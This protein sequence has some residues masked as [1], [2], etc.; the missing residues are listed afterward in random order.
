MS[1][2]N[3][4]I[5][6]LFVVLVIILAVNPKTVNNIYSSILGR[7]FLIGVIIFFAMHNTTL[8][9]LVALAVITALNQYGSFTEGMENATIGDDNVDAT[10]GQI[11][12]TK[13]AVENA[14]KKISDL[15]QDISDGTS[16]IDKEDIKM[17]IMSKD[18]KTIPV[19]PNM[20]SSEEVDASSQGML[21]S[22]AKLEGFSTY[23]S[24]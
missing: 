15:K 22:S 12:L 11:V 7:L 17:A 21:N 18:S 3:Q 19:D 6:V 2:K 23:T 10:G 13:S 20:T 8:G 4:S 14:K 1:V 9:L 5:G 16:G 24:V